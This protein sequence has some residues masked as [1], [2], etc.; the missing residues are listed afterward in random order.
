MAVRGDQ[1]GGGHI[2]PSRD[3]I[4]KVFFSVLD[5]VAFRN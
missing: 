2:P 5:M 1:K 4:V 3:D